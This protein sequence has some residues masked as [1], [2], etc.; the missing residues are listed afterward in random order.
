[1]KLLN[2]KTMVAKFVTHTSACSTYLISNINCINAFCVHTET[3]RESPDPSFSMRDTE[4][5]PRWG[6][7][8]LACETMAAGCCI[9]YH[10]CTCAVGLEGLLVTSLVGDFC[11]VAR[12]S[13]GMQL[14]H[15]RALHEFD[16]QRLL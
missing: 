10:A 3:Y 16:F 15:V 1:M 7:L 6:W 11:S 2:R 12:S 9:Q 8:G 5:D 14:T 4:S 13:T